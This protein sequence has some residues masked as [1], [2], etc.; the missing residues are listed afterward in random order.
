[1]D[2]LMAGCVHEK[3]CYGVLG[4]SGQLMADLARFSVIVPGG[5]S[6]AVFAHR[7]SAFLVARHSRYPHSVG[8]WATWRRSWQLFDYKAIPE[9]YRKHIW[10]Q[11]WWISFKSG[12]G[13]CRGH[14]HASTTFKE[15]M[16]D[17]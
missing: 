5:R 1:M 15:M 13:R 10:D 3:S 7:C 12:G 11:Q 17:A 4:V 16:H 2:A 14:S 6:I 8:G 9:E